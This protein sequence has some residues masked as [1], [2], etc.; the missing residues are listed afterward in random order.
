MQ[1][2]LIIIKP[3]AVD[4]HLV[5]AILSRFEAKGLQ[6]LA[7]KLA[8]I[9]RAT[10]EKHY[11]VHR[12]RHFYAGLVD[13]MTGGPVVLMVLAGEDAIGIARTLMGKTN[14]AEAAPGTI[15]GDFGMA[16]Q[17]NLVHG[18]DGPESAQREIDL[19]FSPEE[20]VEFS[21]S[22]VTWSTTPD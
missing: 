8:I 20:V 9:P 13:F 16:G 11:E 18:S 15:R 17:Y 10:A 6:L 4:R 12:E 1:K 14:S 19:F 21:H 22:D 2:T 5:G 3:D 7:M